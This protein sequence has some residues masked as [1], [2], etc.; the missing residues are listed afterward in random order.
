METINL[1]IHSHDNDYGLALGEALSVYKNNFIVKV[2]RLPEEVPAVFDLIVLDSGDGDISG[3]YAKDKTI[4]L[5]ESRADHIKDI[6]S[7]TFVLYKYM[8]VKELAADIILYYS[9][10]TGKRNFSRA[11][12]KTK[13][14]TFCGAKGG[15]G[16]TTVALGLGQ[17]LRRYHSKSVLYLSMEETEST[18]LYMER[19]CDGLDL[20]AYLYY[21]FKQ[22]GGKPDS[23]AFMV[24]D[25]Y[26]VK[27][28]MPA[29]GLNKIRELD[30]GKMSLF[31]EELAACGA[32]DYILVDMGESFNRGTKWIF[33]ISSKIIVVSDSGRTKNVRESRYLE[34]LKFVVGNDASETDI[35]TVRNKVVDGEDEDAGDPDEGDGLVYIEFDPDSMENFGAISEISIDRDFGVGIKRLMKLVV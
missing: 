18:L 32:Y 23:E 1:I 31:F 3:K 2:C 20:C 17:A 9:L 4:K 29:F 35:I 21:L 6:E 12:E 27:A 28:F 34:Y 26:G 5:T 15:V 13:V 16:K 22:G 24:S 8:N 11:G 10:L 30:D 25:K 33:N 19:R 14:M 7:K